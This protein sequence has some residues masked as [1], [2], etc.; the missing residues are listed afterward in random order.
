MSSESIKS[1]SMA[2][3]MHP[4]NCWPQNYKQVLQGG[5]GLR[6][7][8]EFFIKVPEEGCWLARR[9]QGG[10]EKGERGEGIQWEEKNGSHS[11]MEE[12]GFQLLGNPCILQPEGHLSSL[13]I[14]SWYSAAPTQSVNSS[15]RAE[16]GSYLGVGFNSLSRH[17]YVYWENLG[18][19]WFYSSFNCIKHFR[20]KSSLLL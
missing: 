5:A 13:V 17:P 8:Q 3:K 2:G 7:S 1:E 11:A 9:G 19:S 18:Q 12:L 15:Q 10:I 20:K 6:C 4:P 16:G 14:C